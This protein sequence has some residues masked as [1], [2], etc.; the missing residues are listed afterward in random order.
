MKSLYET[1][2]KCIECTEKKP[3]IAWLNTLRRTKC[4]CSVHQNNCK[5]LI[6]NNSSKV[7]DENLNKSYATV[8]IFKLNQ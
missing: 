3:L 4:F 7:F 1:M 8:F 6:Q 2:Q 5:L